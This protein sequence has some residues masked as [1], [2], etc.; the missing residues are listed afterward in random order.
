DK[1]FHLG[2]E[3]EMNQI[4]KQLPVKKQTLLFSATLNDKVQDLK[5]K[6]IIHP[7]ILEIS[8]DIEDTASKTAA[9]EEEAYLV[10]SSHKGPFLRY[11]IKTQKWNQILVFVSATRT[12]DNLLAKLKKNG[13]KA[14]VIHGDK[15]QGAR[16]Q[17]LDDFKNRR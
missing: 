11:L 15:T 2:F 10:S 5:E 13:I 1:L 16:S 14:S 9:I 17:A 3:E 7:V 8:N 12:A 6:L 4:M